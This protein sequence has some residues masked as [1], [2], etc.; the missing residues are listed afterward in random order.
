MTNPHAQ[1]LVAKLTSGRR[2]GE[3]DCQLVRRHERRLFVFAFL[4]ACVLLPVVVVG[5]FLPERSTAPLLIWV[6]VAIWQVYLWLHCRHV[7][8]FL[9]HDNAA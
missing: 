2:T 8:R 5:F 1:R 7:R 9:E 3:S 6:A 4:S